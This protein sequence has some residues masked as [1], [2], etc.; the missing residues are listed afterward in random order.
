MYNQRTNRK[1]HNGG[2][3]NEDTCMKTR[4]TENMKIRFDHYSFILNWVK[5]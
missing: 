4:E 5:L 1:T 3:Y 2:F